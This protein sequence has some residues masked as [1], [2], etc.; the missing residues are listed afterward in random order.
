MN[1]VSTGLRRDLAGQF[2]NAKLLAQQTAKRLARYVGAELR[3]SFQNPPITGPHIYQ[4]VGIDPAAVSCIFDVGANVGQSAIAFASAFP[5]S[6]IHCFE[7]FKVTFE[8]LCENTRAMGDRIILN[9]MAC[10]DSV[11]TLSVVTGNDDSQLNKLIV[12]CDPSAT[13]IDVG[14]VDDYC[15][16]HN[17]RHIDILKTDTEGFDVSVLRGARCMLSDELVRCVVS[18]I[19]VLNDLQHS[20]FR[21][22]Y[23]LMIDSG[24]EFGGIFEASYFKSGRFDFANALFIRRSI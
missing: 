3:Y 5:K 13:M 16:T 7:P 22:V 9:H 14:T 2:T 18:E 4:A 24:F 11:Q 8:R 10:G 20:H 23:Q 1:I 21:E 6:R 17:V 15:N 19:G 12:S